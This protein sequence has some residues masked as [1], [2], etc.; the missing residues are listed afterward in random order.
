MLSYYE[1]LQINEAATDAEIKKAYRKLCKILHP[2]LHNNSKE[3]NVIFNLLH[4]AYE[5]LSSPEKR[6]SYNPNQ[7]SSSTFDIS[8]EKYD[9][10]ITGYKEIVK[11]FERIIK[12][13]DKRESDL[14]EEIRKLKQEKNQTST[15]NSF[16]TESQK[17]E[18]V[19]S[20]VNTKEKEQHSVLEK[21]LLVGFWVIVVGVIILI[22]MIPAGWWFIIGLIGL[23]IYFFFSISK[24]I[25]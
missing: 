23:P 13:K 8:N 3:A 10:I 9:D 7:Q 19:K 22:V 25:V 4:E 15:I 11:D 2:D 14:L 21:I 16:N 24:A 6:R 18:E 1:I 17:E 12:S 20:P 5:T